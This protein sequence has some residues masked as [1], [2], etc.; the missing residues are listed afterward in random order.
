VASLVA[1]F[2]AEEGFATPA[3]AVRARARPFLESPANAAVLALRGGGP[4]GIA[5]LTTAFGFETGRYGEIEDLYVVP[6]HRGRGVARAL[7]DAVV[8]E[9]RSIGCHDVEIVVTPGAER[10]RGLT[11][12]YERL[13]WRD[14]GRRILDREL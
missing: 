5:T 2:F 13:G 3:A 1:R 10:S 6:E 4:V 7:L 12:F 8:A 14:T 9:A 11:A